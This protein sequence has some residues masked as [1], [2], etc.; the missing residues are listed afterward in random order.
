ML[1]PKDPGVCTVKIY[2]TEA[3]SLLTK[4][5]LKISWVVPKPEYELGCTYVCWQTG[6]APEQ[7]CCEKPINDWKTSNKKN[8]N[9]IY[10]DLNLLKTIDFLEIKSTIRNDLIKTVY[11]IQF[12]VNEFKEIKQ[13]SNSKKE[14]LIIYK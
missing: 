1:N 14:Q 8:K 7:S 5:V 4:Q 12:K 11:H 10:V 9:W 13:N 2:H 3:C 6:I